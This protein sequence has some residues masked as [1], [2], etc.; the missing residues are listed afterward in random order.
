MGFPVLDR[1]FSLTSDR[2]G[3]FYRIN[4]KNG[5]KADIC[6][7][8]VTLAYKADVSLKNFLEFNDMSELDVVAIGQIYYIEEKKDKG[9]IEYHTATESESLWDISMLY[10]I[11]LEDILKYNRLEKV[12]RLQRGRVVYLQDKRPKNQPIEYKVIPEDSLKGIELGND[13]ILSSNSSFKWPDREDTF[14]LESALIEI[15]AIK[16]PIVKEVVVKAVLKDKYT[17]NLKNKVLVK[18]ENVVPEFVVHT[19]EKRRDFI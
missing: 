16:E 12:E 7:T 17:E 1:D 14:K 8:Y 6:D 19:G 4:G 5:I 18:D 2:G 11:K 9:P 15:E 13:P 3:D 10:A